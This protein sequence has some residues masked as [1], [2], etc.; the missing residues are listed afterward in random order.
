[1]NDFFKL[2][3]NLKKE[4]SGLKLI[5]VA[6]LGDTATQFLNQALRGTGYDYGFNLQLFETDFDQVE[7]Q[8]FDETSELYEFKP[9][10]I[11]IFQSCHKL[12]GKY[13]KQASTARVH[14]ADERL[15]LVNNLYTT[16][17]SRLGS[18]VIY[19]NYSEINDSVFGNYANK[20]ESS[21]LYQQRKLNFEL[22]NYAIQHPNFYICDLASIQNFS[23]K[24]N[25]FQPSIYVNT[26]MVLSI[27]V[28]PLVTARTLD[29]I[30][31]MYGRS[32]K[33]LILD[34]DNTLWGGVIGD[35]GIEN[36]QLGTLGIG[37]AF[38]EFQEWLKKLKDRG[39]IL[40][41][42][43]KNTE[44]VAREP[45][46]KHPDM[47]LRME[48]IAVFVANWENKAD[49]IRFIQSTLN[50]GFDAMVFLDDNPFERNIVRENIP[51]I[52]IPELPE[53]PADYLEF[54][55]T[56]NLFE[57]I[58]F[59]GEDAERT[60]L[61]KVEAERAD[62]QKKFTNEEDFLK[63]LEMVSVV[64]PFT[65]FNIPRV[66]QLSQRSNQFNLRTVRYVESDIELLA[67]S[68]DHFSFS[69]TLK[70][71]FGESGMICVVILKKA[72][73][74]T[75]FIDSWYMSCR[76]LKRG[77]ENFVLNTIS[78]YATKKNYKFIKGEYLPTS[79]NQMVKD[80]YALLGFEKEGEQWI[81]DLSNFKK[82]FT[83]IKTHTN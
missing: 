79:K 39:I 74:K 77:M 28:L 67:S 52:T 61:Y 6:L 26:E 48:D 20:Q 49:N 64:E 14:L 63:N 68:P 58:S 70:D 19:Y 16:L 45:F 38:T 75:L 46:E 55:Y 23:G 18:K 60:N 82:R 11:I 54:L 32:K 80:H 1:M 17:S 59:S 72:D 12:L 65:K 33:C 50:I 53:D 41:V 81:L 78:E 25:I 71:K 47:V 31:A 7:R 56:L 29:I 34:L 83:H 40:A 51:E 69:F 35:D 4:Y 2:K 66:A 13:N 36:I 76:V 43:S 37:K 62:L 73:T 27:D 15:S 24:S 9:D 21:F 8:I 57:T 44:S 5:K 30:G 10:I 42:C 3:S 22:M